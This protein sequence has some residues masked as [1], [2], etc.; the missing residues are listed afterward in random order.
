MVHF[1]FVYENK[2]A[3]PTYL[4]R[5][6]DQTCQPDNGLE[7]IEAGEVA[8]GA[9]CSMSQTDGDTRTSALRV[10]FNWVSKQPESRWNF[11]Q[12]RHRR[13]GRN[14]INT[15]P[16]T[17]SAGLLDVDAG[18]GRAVLADVKAELGLDFEAES[19]LEGAEEDAEKDGVNEAKRNYGRRWL[20]A[21]RN[22]PREPRQMI[23][24]TGAPGFGRL[25]ISW[26]PE[27]TTERRRTWY[28]N[29]RRTS[30]A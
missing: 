12:Q 6:A 22:S 17:S 23:F 27:M 24:R 10:C 11:E 25:C 30:R 29:T 1:N 18:R 19:E 7:E 3:G 8:Q 9:H 16:N 20:A 2:F 14:V 13:R 21:A 5:T 26:L 4:R 28:R 15:S